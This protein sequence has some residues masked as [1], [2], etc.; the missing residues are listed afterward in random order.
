MTFTEIG[1]LLQPVVERYRNEIISVYLFG[2]AASRETHPLSDIDIGVLL[3]ESSRSFR[4][5]KLS[6]YADFCRVLK[7]NDVDVVV[8]NGT[9]NLVLLEQII[10]AGVVLVDRDRD[11]REEFEQRTLHRAID[12]KT[13]RVAN[14]GI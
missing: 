8:L 5:M 7:R 4:D 6:L 11:R 14:M 3:S 2:S 9:D 1:S 10:R 12:F 13:Q